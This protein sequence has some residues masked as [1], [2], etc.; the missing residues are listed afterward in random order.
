MKKV[1]LFFSMLVI[2]LTTGFTLI[3][4]SSDSDND[5]IKDPTV[6]QVPQG[7][8][9]TIN[10]TKGSNTTRALLDNGTTLTSSWTVGDEVKVYKEGNF[11]GTLNAQSAGTTTKL[12]GMLTSAPSVDDL[13]KLEYSSPNYDTQ[14]GTL[15]GNETS[16]DKVCDYALAF[17]TVESIDANNKITIKEANASFSS[18]QAIIKFTLKNKTNN[19]PLNVKPLYVSANG[20]T[21]TINPASATDVLYV[22]VP[23]VDN[24]PF[25]LAAPIGED[26]YSYRHDETTFESGK[27]YTR[28]VKMIKDEG[29]AFADVTSAHKRWFIG[30]N[31]KVYMT[32]TAATA[33]GTTPVAC[34]AYVGTE[35]DGYFSK[36]LAIALEDVD[37]YK[38]K[39]KSELM[40]DDVNNKVQKWMDSHIVDGY[41][42]SNY[43][44]D[45]Q[46]Y[47]GAANY[48][49]GIS[50]ILRFSTHEKGW[51]VPSLL[52]WFLVYHGLGGIPVPS[53]ITGNTPSGWIENTTNHAVNIA[54]QGGKYGTSPSYMKTTSTSFYWINTGSAND[55]WPFY[56]FEAALGRL[57]RTSNSD[58]S[59]RPNYTYARLVFAY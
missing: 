35:Y 38:I 32:K 44:S 2:L 40:S 15:T 26:V 19:E 27:F 49:V 42:H 55:S 13:L 23:Y 12:S 48:G 20:S 28:T 39:R 37:K 33:A 54:C 1:F 58:S 4:C 46:Y 53:T 47:D 14:D 51:R 43:T 7:Y 45:T 5:I 9:F 17:V 16:I 41:P 57:F 6:N 21:Y 56:T 3:S 8:T 11:I 52:D 59:D 10:A 24:L 50:P 36:F 30:Q 22:A 31:S 34:I 29:V 18:Q 25:Y